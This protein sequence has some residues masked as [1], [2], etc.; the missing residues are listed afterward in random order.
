MKCSWVMSSGSTVRR[1]RGGILWLV[2]LS[3]GHLQASIIAG[4]VCIPWVE[5]MAA[6]I[7]WASSRVMEERPMKA[8]RKARF[9]SL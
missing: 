2:L 8:C 3:V 1:S 4:G 7:G 6:R 5:R 9:A